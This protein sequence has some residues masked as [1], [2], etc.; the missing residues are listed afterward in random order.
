MT[1]TKTPTIDDLL[2]EVEQYEIIFSSMPIM[3]WYKDDQ[4]NV[5]RV[6]EAAAQFEGTSRE[7]IEGKTSWDLYPK[8]QADA[9][10]ADDM[11][12]IQSSKPKL[13]I[14]E[15]H[16]SPTTGEVMW[17]QT[18]KVPYRNR[19]KKITGVI[20]FAVDITEQKKAELALQES[21]KTLEKKNQHLQRVQEFIRST[22]SHIEEV[23]KHGADRAEIIGYCQNAL[24]DL[25]KLE[26]RF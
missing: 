16:T 19:D 2:R 7:N 4:N 22:L 23:T 21:N 3:L 26:R 10:Y 24:A 20:A 11:E 1:T 18:G 5:V 6:N 25:E 8:A 14:I 13:N 17:V 12:V 9:F 15:S